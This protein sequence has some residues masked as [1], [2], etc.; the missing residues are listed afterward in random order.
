[1][2]SMKQNKMV[3][4]EVVAEQSDVTVNEQIYAALRE[5]LISGEFKPGELV[6]IQR[7]TARFGV[8]PTPA[9][10]AVRRLVAEGA[11]EAPAN[12]TTR[13]PQI[14]MAKFEQLC[15]AR[16]LLE[17]W[18]TAQAAAAMDRAGLQK[19]RRIN[20]T[21][22]SAI[23]AGDMDE[24]AE[25]NRAFH[26][27]IYSAA[28]NPLIVGLIENLWVQ[29]GPYI[30]AL[31]ETPFYAEIARGHD[32]LHFHSKI[33]KALEGRKSAIAA[34]AMRADIQT[35]LDWYRKLMR[36]PARKFMRDFATAVRPLRRKPAA[37]VRQGT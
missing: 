36:E 3:R 13:V 33:L 9:R 30:R 14:S 24:V 7:V 23:D 25:R 4:G 11:L 31:A 17:A 22:Q 32:Y 8:S 34:Q 20:E 29:S 21:L 15:A 37:L 1:V 10:E 18:A 16:S 12:R 28:Q 6:P 27:T 35:T 2:E 5:A 26:F 19:L